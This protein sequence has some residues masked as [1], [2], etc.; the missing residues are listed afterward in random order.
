MSEYVYA[1]LTSQSI[2]VML[3][4]SSSTT[5]AGLTGLVYN[6]SGLKAYYRK[7]ATGT[8][9]AITLATQTVGGAFSSGG[10][11]EVDSTNMAGVYRLDLPNAAVDTEGFVTL[12]IY[13]ATNLVPTAQRI[14]C[15]A[16]PVDVKKFGATN[17]T[18]ASGR[19]EVNATHVAGTSQT[20]G[21]I[22]GILGALNAAASSGDPGTTT[23]LVQY[24]KQIIN[25]LEGS[26]GI[27]TFPAAAAPANAVSLAEV[28]RS[29]YTQIGVA[30][31]G[32]TA[33][34]D[35]RMDN[36]DAAVSTLATAT[37]LAA[38]KTV[39]DAI[40]AIVGSGTY[41]NQA[42]KTAVDA[43]STAI[44]NL[45]NL[46]ALANLRGPS[47]L[48]IPDSSTLV[49]KFLLTIFDQEGKLV[50]LDGS[51]TITAA[52]AAGTD[53]SSKLS[54]VTNP[55][56]GQ[57]EF[58]YT[59][60][61]TDAEESVAIKANGTISGEA[62]FAAISCSV[63]NYDSLTTINSILTNVNAL[64]TTIGTAG[65]GLTNLGDARLDNL[66]AT[67]S[68]RLATS[69]YTAPDNSTISTIN[70]KLGTPSDLGGGATI[71]ANLS[72]IESQTDDIGA[73][74]AGLTGIP[75]TG[76][77]LASDGLDQIPVTDPGAVATTF[78]NMIVQLWRRFFKK[79]T[80]TSSELKT[81]ADDGTT[82]RT[83]QAVSD[84]GTTQTQGPAT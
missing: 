44:G 31:A 64:I 54:A 11:V 41:G 8:A 79:S 30:G 75:K 43:I 45:N 55:A 42:I 78:P 68:S 72:D 65:V 27:P 17:G 34:G 16:L 10:F 6:S 67:V 38:A 50:A 26:A 40:N 47:V 2:D 59:V 71:A 76:F 23:T 1:G 48:E 53:R 39:I 49:Y 3:R 63:V 69:G 52:N 66:N 29:I 37:N 21:D 13:G 12:F 5:G 33:I 80:L 61:S 20:A 70:T 57:Y 62:R 32:L 25:T 60:S 82:V 58:T 74:G 83:T 81:Y 46:A 15:R 14:D 77:K 7:G 84:D 56:T 73:A 35:T 4:D 9:T 28:I 51:P 18:F 19:P 24:L 36:L 22:P